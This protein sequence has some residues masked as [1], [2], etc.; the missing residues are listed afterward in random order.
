M[1]RN[2]TNQNDQS[3]GPYFASKKNQFFNNVLNFHLALDGTPIL[4]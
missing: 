1:S 4:M 3:N 2:L